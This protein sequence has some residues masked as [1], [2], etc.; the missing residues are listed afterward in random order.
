MSTE[1][2]FPG[3]ILKIGRHF[4]RVKRNFIF[5]TRIPGHLHACAHAHAR[6]ANFFLKIDFLV[7]HMGTSLQVKIA[8][9][10]GLHPWLW[11]LKLYVNKW[12]TRK[13]VPILDYSAVF[14]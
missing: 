4:E 9:R 13:S 3:R 12:R 1:D 7:Q 10:Y 14:A 5:S 6:M 11:L 2:I 8:S